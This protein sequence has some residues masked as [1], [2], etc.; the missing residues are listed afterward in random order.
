MLLMIAAA[1]IL[2]SLL[3]GFS[4]IYVMAII[5]LLAILN[6]FVFPFGIFIN[7][8]IIDPYLQLPLLFVF[9]VLTV[10][11]FTDFVRGGA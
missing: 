10:L 11:G 6:F 3:L 8:A 9:N 2:S 4:A 5:I 7:D 1:G